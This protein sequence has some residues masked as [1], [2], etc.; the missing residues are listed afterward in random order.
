MSCDLSDPVRGDLR[1]DRTRGNALPARGLA[2]VRRW[3]PWRRWIAA[4]VLQ[5]PLASVILGA[6][7]VLGNTVN[8]GIGR[9]IGPPGLQRPLTAC[10]RCST[11]DAPRSSS[12]AMARMA[13]LLSRFVPIIRT[14]APFV[15]G[16]GRMPYARFL[17]FNFAGGFAWGAAVSSGAAT[18]RPTI[19]FVRGA[20]R[21]SGHAAHHRRITGACWRAPCGAA[22]RPMSDHGRAAA[23]TSG[24]R[25][26]RDEGPMI[27]PISSARFGIA[28]SMKPV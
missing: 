28:V 17:A 22:R 24:A 3:A 20:L 11:S 14:C 21:S 6:A 7:A 16:V 27:A 2:A 5:A 10:S 1:G 9:A 13:I 18:V 25:A 12:G 26:E 4:G 23:G 15:A 19:A 8:Y